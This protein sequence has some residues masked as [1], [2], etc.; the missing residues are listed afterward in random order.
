MFAHISGGSMVMGMNSWA[1][2]F[3]WTILGTTGSL[4]GRTSTKAR[5]WLDCLVTFSTSTHKTPKISVCNSSSSLTPVEVSRP[6]G[7]PTSSNSTLLLTKEEKLWWDVWQVTKQ[8]KGSIKVSV[9][10]V[11]DG[12]M[13]TIVG[14]PST[15]AFTSQGIPPNLFK[16]SQLTPVTSFTQAAQATRSKK[17]T[18]LT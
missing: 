6:P 13:L 11:K 12:C 9:R 17:A 14:K 1:N 2:K 3:T 8:W 4:V 7:T 15:A 16:W 10:K 18:K 5:Q